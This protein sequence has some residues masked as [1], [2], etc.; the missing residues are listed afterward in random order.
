LDIKDQKIILAS[1]SPYRKELLKRLDITFT[2][3]SP[4]INE[5]YFQDELIS[6]YVLRLAKTKAES[7]VPKN[8]NSLI[9]AADQALQCDKKI[10]GKPGNYNKA[11]EQLIFMSN[12]SLT[13]YT[14]LCL[15]NTETKIIEEDVVSFRVDFRKLTE[16]EI[17]NYLVKEKPYDCVG[18]FKSEKL[19]I[20]LLK[21]MNGDD[22]TAL[23]G[24]P[25]I[26]LCKMLRNQGVD[27]P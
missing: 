21:K 6:D 16:S 14:G 12:R 11:K 24:L 23:I 3:V 7:I 2:T 4:E 27:I 8:N 20:S 15:I 9:I 17:E 19:G 10:L 22:P 25:L 5:R 1:S 13:F 26:R 18:S